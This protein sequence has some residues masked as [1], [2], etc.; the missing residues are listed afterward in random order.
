MKSTRASACHC[1]E[2][3]AE[4]QLPTG[5]V[6][7]TLKNMSSFDKPCVC[8]DSA[9]LGEIRDHIPQPWFKGC[10]HDA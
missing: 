4:F 8:I 1:Q 10:G 7:K 3:A 5:G 6:Y 9:A 2:V